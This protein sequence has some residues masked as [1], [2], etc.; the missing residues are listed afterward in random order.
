MKHLIINEYKIYSKCY[1]QRTF[2][3]PAQ[4]V[5]DVKDEE[6]II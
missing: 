6:C 1:I 4:D 5:L 3:Y 2:L